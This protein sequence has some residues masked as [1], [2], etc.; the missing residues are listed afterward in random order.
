MLWDPV[1][2]VEKIQLNP[3]HR[4]KGVGL[5]AMNALLDYFKSHATLA[6]C[7]PCP[8]R[9]PENPEYFDPKSA[10]VPVRSA[11]AALQRYWSKA[12]YRKLGRGPYYVVNVKKRSA[13]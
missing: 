3:T 6:F 11:T 5:M 7:K 12:G 10:K 9:K 2:Y 13:E 1:L 8:I 4:G